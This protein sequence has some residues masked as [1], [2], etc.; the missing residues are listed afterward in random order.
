M[1]L[2]DKMSLAVDEI[3]IYLLFTKSSYT[4]IQLFPEVVDD[5]ADENK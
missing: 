4:S 1:A 2:N 5:G 3:C